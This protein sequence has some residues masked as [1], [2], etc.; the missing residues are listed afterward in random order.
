[1]RG[2]LKDTCHSL[3]GL[4]FLKKAGGEKQYLFSLL[5][6]LRIY[7]VIAYSKQEKNLN[8][9]KNKIFSHLNG[10]VFSEM[11]HKLYK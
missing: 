11:V 3:L 4:Q 5:Q 2:I 9:A 10:A 1:M 8:L 6:F 7:R